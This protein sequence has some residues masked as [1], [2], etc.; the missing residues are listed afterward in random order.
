MNECLDIEIPCTSN[1]NSSQF[2]PNQ[3][4]AGSGQFTAGSG[5][6]TAGSGQFTAGSGQFTT[7]S[8]QITT[9]PGQFA[10][11]S[12]QFTAGPTQGS[13]GS[14]SP[15]NQFEF[16]AS[17]ERPTRG[18]AKPGFGPLQLG[19][20]GYQFQSS[21]MYEPSKFETGLLYDSTHPA[22]LRSYPMEN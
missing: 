16:E 20:H 11:A 12:G 4:T 17:L 2:R 10:A 7:G 15:Q 5:Q 13:S 21:T 3:F 8:G 1:Q 14:T 22:Q 18:Q 19:T 9:R 6:F